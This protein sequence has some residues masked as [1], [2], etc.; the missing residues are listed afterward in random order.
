MVFVPGSPRT[1]RRIAPVA[2]DLARRDVPIGVPESFLQS[3]DTSG[4]L[5]PDRSG[6][7]HRR[8]SRRQLAWVVR[9]RAQLDEGH[10]LAAAA[11]IV[12]LQDQLADAEDQT[13][14]LRQQLAQHGTGP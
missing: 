10:A 8:Y 14:D 11:R 6:G 1:C 3:L 4:V 13:S 5:C 2:T 9:L 7:G 12:G